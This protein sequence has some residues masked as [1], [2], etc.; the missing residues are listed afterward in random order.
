MFTSTRFR[1]ALCAAI[2]LGAALA[3]TPGAAD[4][5]RDK[6][7]PSD[8]EKK[9]QADREA[10]INDLM[11]AYRLK[12]LGSDKKHPSAAA[13]LAAAD[14]FRQLSKV[15]LADLEVKP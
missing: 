13:L 1:W 5:Q 4:A 6:K 3:L 7:D 15:S 10:Y 8:E 2:A 9:T 14:L 12:E 11:L